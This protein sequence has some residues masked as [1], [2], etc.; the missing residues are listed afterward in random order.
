MSR[1][2]HK[3][4][5]KTHGIWPF[6]ISYLSSSTYLVKPFVGQWRRSYI[7]MFSE[8]RQIIINI[9]RRLMNDK[10]MNRRDVKHFMIV[11]QNVRT[12]ISTTTPTSLTKR[13]VRTHDETYVLYFII[14][15]Y[16]HVPTCIYGQD[17]TLLCGAAAVRP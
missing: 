17:R 3:S 2:N 13:L 10:H 7:E 6:S 5:S 1:F 14:Y 9:V 11:I 8:K 15:T 4:E 12:C 16:Y